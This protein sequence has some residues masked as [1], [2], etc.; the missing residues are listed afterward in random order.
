[1]TEICTLVNSSFPIAPGVTVPVTPGSEDPRHDRM[2]AHTAGA[3]AAPVGAHEQV[4]KF[5]SPCLSARECGLLS[6]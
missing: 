2:G 4:V 1:M 5:R 6:G 3:G